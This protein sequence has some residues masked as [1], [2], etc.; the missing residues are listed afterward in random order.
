MM[1]AKN[2]G[3]AQHG[4]HKKVAMKTSC[5]IESQKRSHEK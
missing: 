3:V 2:H 4:S 1:V 5:E